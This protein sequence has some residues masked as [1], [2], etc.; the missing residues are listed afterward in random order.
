MAFYILAGLLCTFTE[1]IVASSPPRDQVLS[2]NPQSDEEIQ[3]VKQICSQYQVVFWQPSSIDDIR[4]NKEIHLYVNASNIEEVKNQLA[5]ATITY[6]VLIEDVQQ[7]IKKQKN[8]ALRPRG[9]F[10]YYETYHPLEEIYLWMSEITNAYPSFIQK[11]LI[12]PSSEKRL[13]YVLKLFNGTASPKGAVWIDCGIHAR[14]WI[15]PA[16]CQWF[17]QYLIDSQDTMITDILKSFEIYILPIWN[18]DGYEYTWTTNRFWRKNLSKHNRGRCRG[19]DLNRNWDASWCGPGASNNPCSETYCGRHPESEPEVKAV[20]TFIRQ[21]S[22]HIKG[23]ISIHSYSQM[24]M[25]PY[26]YKRSKSKDHKELNYVAQKAVIAV[27]SVHGT[28]YR[29][30]NSATSTY[31]SSGCSDDWAYDL[32]IKYSFTFELRDTGRYGFLLPPDLIKPT[33]E[34]ATAAVSEILRH[35]TQSI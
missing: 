10:S 12:G 17:V 3:F 14:E 1:V 33:C 5:T 4:L 24:V 11:I 21:R 2:I 26:S 28:N 27:R 23:Y 8:E 20:A 30:G 34:E 22:D 32:G 35:I 7:L 6:R 16:F 13:I 31:L 25:F 9:F 19:T 15:A 18:V 29:Y